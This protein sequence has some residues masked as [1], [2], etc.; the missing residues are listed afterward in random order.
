MNGARRKWKL[1]MPA[2]PLVDLF[3]PCAGDAR[4]QLEA[5]PELERT[6]ERLVSD[7]RAAW[8]EL[9]IDDARLLAYLAE[10]LPPDADAARALARV[11]APDLLLA[12]AC[13]DGDESAL[14]E[15]ERQFMPEIAAYVARL[16]SSPSFADDV[17]QALR[18]RLL[19]SEGGAR[20]KIASYTG[21]GPLGAW[22]RVAAVRTA[23]NLLRAR[24]PEVPL[25]DTGRVQLRSERPDPELDYLKTR[26]ARD[27]E[28]AFSQTLA[29]LGAK[30][31][32]ILS[33]Y[34]LD[35]MSSTAIGALYRVHQATVR[36]WIEKLREAIVKE[37][38][39]RLRE[40]ISVGPGELESLMLL[41]Q[42]RLEVSI[43]RVLRGGGD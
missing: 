9:A 26:Y 23:R 30:E 28:Q 21:A 14:A 7:A 5:W 25:D 12:A 40:R 11:H 24:K 35:G 10:R 34:F 3:L 27:L 15:L 22:L 42:S 39:R 4:A 13:A 19:V 32:N 38:Q 43:S 6:L 36:R 31:R 20:P 41:V 16:D 33:L 37:T 2:R 18:H 17:R 29:S 8:P 1:R